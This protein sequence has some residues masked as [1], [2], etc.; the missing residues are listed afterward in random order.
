MTIRTWTEQLNFGIATVDEQHLR[1][2][3]ILNQLDEAV[4]LGYEH[5]RVLQIVD[6][7]IDYTKYHFQPEF[8]EPGI[9]QVNWAPDGSIIL[10][11]SELDG[12]L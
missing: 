3:D 5:K 1:P 11:E 10:D 8:E 2:V 4:A 6:A 7:L 12:D 9:T